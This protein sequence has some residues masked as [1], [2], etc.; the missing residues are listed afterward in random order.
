MTGKRYA[1]EI[2]G[3]QMSNSP[4]GKYVFPN[5]STSFGGRSVRMMSMVDLPKPKR[6]KE[7]GMD[8]KTADEGG[9]A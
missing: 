7:G 5:C 2:P 3:E 9:G 4:Q 8:A 6:M 1:G